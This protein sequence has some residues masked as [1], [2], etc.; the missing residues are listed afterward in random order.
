MINPVF[1]QN[2][3]FLGVVLARECVKYTL[4]HKVNWPIGSARILTRHFA[5]MHANLGR[6][7]R[8]GCPSTPEDEMYE[9][10]NGRDESRNGARDGTGRIP[11]FSTST[12]TAAAGRVVLRNEVKRRLLS[13][14]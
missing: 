6:Y 14:R 11:R 5:V 12:T 13:Q 8:S 10:S 3:A 4:I 9:A 1:H 2:S 7:G